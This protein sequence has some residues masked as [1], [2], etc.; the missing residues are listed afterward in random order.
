[1]VRAQSNHSL[2]GIYKGA[3][4]ERCRERFPTS[5]SVVG[6]SGV[7]TAAC[8]RLGLDFVAAGATEINSTPSSDLVRQIMRQSRVR[9]ARGD[10]NNMNSPGRVAILGAVRRAPVFDKLCT[11]HGNVT[12]APWK[13][14]RAAVFHSTRDVCRRSRRG[15]TFL[16]SSTL[17]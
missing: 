17:L 13:R 2:G 1:M 16:F 8:N 11:T 10:N 14:I 15:M 4:K 12:R 9:S 7:F 5:S 6:A 3:S